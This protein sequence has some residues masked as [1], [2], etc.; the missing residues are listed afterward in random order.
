MCS[1][2]THRRQ[3][4]AAGSVAPTHSDA[5]ELSDL[6]QRPGEQSCILQ[7]IQQDMSYLQG[8]LWAAQLWKGAENP[9]GGIWE[10]SLSNG[11]EVPHHSKAAER[12][13]STDEDMKAWA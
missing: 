3:E 11:S 12:F 4:L 8:Q 13:I 5:P 2:H 10:L 9:W 7:G 1:S 6:A